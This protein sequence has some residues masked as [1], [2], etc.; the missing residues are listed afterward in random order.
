MGRPD[1]DI[2]V[3]GAGHA[4]CEAALACARMGLS[5]WMYTLNADSIGLMPCNPSIGGLGKG[6]LV[7]E[8]DALGGEMG[9]AADASCIQYKILGTSKGPAVQGSR[10]QCDRLEYSL[11]M[12]SAVE[13]E[14]DL[15]V[16]QEMV[17]S[18]LLRN[19]GCAG[20][21][22][23]SGYEVTAAAVIL[24]T[25]TFL[26]GVIHVGTVSYG[27]GRSG[28]FPAKELAVQLKALGLPYGRFKTGTPPRAKGSTVDLSVME[29]DSGDD[30]FRPFSLR[31]AKMTRPRRSCF[32]TYTSRRTHEIVRNNLLRSP[33]Y[34]GAIQG[35]PA[36]YCPS[37]EDKVARFPSRERHPIVVEPEGLHTSEVYL[38]GL[39]NSLPP[40]IQINL[41][42]SVPGLE[43]AEIVRPAYAIEY[44]FIHPTALKPTLETKAIGGLYLAGQIN[45]TSGYE[46]AAAQGLWA[47]INAA[48]AVLGREPFILDRSE[49]YMAVMVDDLVTRG[50]NEPYR[51]FTSRAEYRL[52]LRED[53]AAERLVKKGHLLGLIPAQLAN[54]FDEKVRS[55][56]RHIGM[57]EGAKVKPDRE[58][59]GIVLARGGSEIRDSISAAKLLK[60]P[61]IRLDDLVSL[62]ILA[63]DLDPYVARQIEIQIKYEGYIDRQN[64]EA[65]QFRKMEKVLVPQDMDYDEIP[66]LSRE[67]REKL[68]AVAPRSLGQVS[69]VPGVTP[70]ALTAL[71]VKISRRQKW[72][73]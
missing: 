42:R 65:A 26:D 15:L 40:E 56:S 5:V 39:G 31:T 25:G 52:L 45:G 46:E 32:K 33:L 53:N 27:A 55:V 59:N 30:A 36:R 71:M 3:V 43:N 47:G 2:I 28:E 62:G 11:A 44:D 29:E 8:I 18:L 64:R 50:V 73:E 41:I 21:R 69:R 9:R 6:H 63:T 17:D 37:L 10:M 1:V 51:M 12:K 48:H 22:E 70:A 54:E 13:A 72:T 7:K 4:G 57:L 34:S 16:R 58:I 23:R 60:R 14:S 49:S 38:K 19:G 66:G 35:T 61:E 24:A 67:L 68:K 20:V